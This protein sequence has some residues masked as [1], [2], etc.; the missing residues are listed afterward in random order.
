MGVNLRVR[1]YDLLKKNLKEI[2]EDN[3]DKFRRKLWGDIKIGLV[4][5]FLIRIEW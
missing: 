4:K 5:G 2:R 3:N 1:K